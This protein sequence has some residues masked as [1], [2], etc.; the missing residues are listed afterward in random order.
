M[1]RGTDGDRLERSL[2]VG[3]GKSAGG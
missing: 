2:K 3:N 1:L